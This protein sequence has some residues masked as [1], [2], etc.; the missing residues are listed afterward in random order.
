MTVALSTS[1]SFGT[2]PAVVAL[3]L[4]AVVFVAVG[5]LTHEHE[6]AFSSALIYLVVGL[7]AAAVIDG[8]GLP[9]FELLRDPHVLQYVAEL[10]LVFALFAT[11][12][13]IARM[14]RTRSL[15]ALLLL[16]VV[17][18][19]TV[20]AV[21]AFGSLVMGLSLGAAIILGG[22]LAPTDPV[23]AG[24]LGARPPHEAEEEQ[25]DAPVALSV[26]AG[27]NDGIAAPF[28][29]LGVFVAQQGG[30][31]WLSEWVL[32]DVLYGVGVAAAIGALGGYGIAAL[33]LW[34]R[35]HGL[36]A[37]ELDAWVA[38]GAAFV[39][40]GA[41]QAAGAYG[42]I[43]AFVG[44]IAF[45]R[46]QG[47]RFVRRVH[48]SADVA[49]NFAELGTIL[50]FAS[51]VH[52]PSLGQPGVAG[53]LLVPALLLVI[54]PAAVLL[55]LAGLRL[56]LRERLFLAWFG[57]KGVASLY[58]VAAIIAMGVVSPGETATLAWTTV[59]VVAVSIIAHGATATWLRGKLLHAA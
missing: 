35:E 28:V 52:F 21:A 45:R 12:L 48:G 7:A 34:L 1:L 4:G 29:L 54:R 19:V 44:G 6:R 17:M 30:V 27:V 11:G 13:R 32:T 46:Y 49:R 23:L 47:G 5:A 8:F 33:A 55:A 31:G 3:L 18:T 24:G 20:A 56:P 22:M 41:G 25:R 2:T 38:I 51:M 58:Y 40:F 10:T 15:T 57:V 42:F 9:W 50:L 39:I 59:A 16:G 36:V 53:W 14:N 26:E 43:A 37:S